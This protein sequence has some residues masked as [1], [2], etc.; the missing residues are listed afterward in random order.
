MEA[1]ADACR[2]E[3]ARAVEREDLPAA[4]S[5]YVG[6][7][8][9]SRLP[10]EL[11]CAVLDA[12]PRREGAEVTV[13]CNPEDADPGRLA[14]YRAAG[15]TRLS[16]G[17]QSTVAHVLEGLGRRHGTVEVAAAAAAVAAA[18]FPSWNLDL[19]LGGAGEEPDDWRR[20]LDDVLGLP[21]PPPHVSAY[22]LTVEPGTPSRSTGPA[23]RTK[24]PRPSGTKRQTGS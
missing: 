4:A 3:L 19:I 22:A 9:P 11:L 15:V 13:E 5:V 24:T 1:Y 16:L 12:V 18:G 20:S 14:A 23:T 7:G 8:T 6:G 21:D 10:A 2:A 17:V